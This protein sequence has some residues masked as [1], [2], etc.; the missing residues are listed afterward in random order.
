M[1]I[2]VN[3]GVMTS[4]EKYHSSL[5]KFYEFLG[6]STRR[7][8]NDHVWN[9]ALQ[10]VLFSRSHFAFLHSKFAFTI[11]YKSTYANNVFMKIRYI[12]YILKQECLIGR[13]VLHPDISALLSI[14]FFTIAYSNAFIDFFHIFHTIIA[15]VKVAACQP[16]KYIHI[17]I[18]Q[19]QK[20]RFLHLNP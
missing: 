5:G 9:S 19:R 4:A 3:F 10:L 11:A 16:Y 15:N 2:L 1:A 14:D 7:C 20:L 8:Q 6:N 18:L 13:F 17:Y 12:W